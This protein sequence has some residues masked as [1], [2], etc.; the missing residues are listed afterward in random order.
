MDDKPV[1][2]LAVDIMVPR[3]FEIELYDWPD[4]AAMALSVTASGLDLEWLGVTDDY[5]GTLGKAEISRFDVSKTPDG[6][7]CIDSMGRS[8]VTIDAVTEELLLIGLQREHIQEF[9]DVLATAK[10]EE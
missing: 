10:G 7:V 4:E 1:K 6:K 2:K 8:N 5:S 9:V 3:H